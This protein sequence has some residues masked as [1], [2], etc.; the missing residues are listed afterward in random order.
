M[1]YAS[2]CSSRYPELRDQEHPEPAEPPRSPETLGM[3]G[4]VKKLLHASPADEVGFGQPDGL[5]AN[6]GRG[7]SE[8]RRTVL[9]SGCTGTGR[10]AAFEGSRHD[11]QHNW[12][13]DRFWKGETTRVGRHLIR[14]ARLQAAR[15]AGVTVGDVTCCGQGG[16]FVPDGLRIGR[17]FG[18]RCRVVSA[19]N[20]GPLALV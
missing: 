2:D 12:L 1:R 19:W 6:P 16:S 8:S 5:Q 13:T 3:T 7:R 15:H 9:P 18:G 10:G 4:C 11:A 17:E 20:E 14:T